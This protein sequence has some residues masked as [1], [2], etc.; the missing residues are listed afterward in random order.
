[1]VFRRPCPLRLRAERH[2]LVPT[3]AGRAKER[4]STDSQLSETTMIFE[5]LAA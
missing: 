3:A 4:L 1:M 5:R 2:L